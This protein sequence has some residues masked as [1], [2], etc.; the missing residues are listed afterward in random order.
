[1]D[2]INLNGVEYVKKDKIA[3]LESDK[4]NLERKIQSIKEIIGVSFDD[5]KI[6][7]DEEDTLHIQK[8]GSLKRVNMKDNEIYVIRDSC[9]K[10][11]KIK[12]MTSDGDFL[13][14][15]NRILAY[16]IRDVLKVQQETQTPITVADARALR[17]KLDLSP[18]AF[19]MIMYNLEQHVFDKYINDFHAA[20]R[21]KLGHNAL[22]VQNNPEK[23]KE[24]GYY[25]I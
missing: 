15:G 19:S 24:G 7:T 11:Q 3:Q 25:N 10:I 14:Y 17:K 12:M 2:I 18:Y 13:S 21:P 8:D 16:N 23:R 1:M 4:K 20:Q 6:A 5:I 22:P 9:K